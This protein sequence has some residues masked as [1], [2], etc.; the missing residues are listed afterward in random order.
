[1]TR[2]EARFLIR[3]ILFSIG[4]SRMNR[5]LIGEKVLEAFHEHQGLIKSVCVRPWKKKMGVHVVVHYEIWGPSGFGW[6][7]G[8]VA[9]PLRKLTPEIAVVQSV[10]LT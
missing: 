9:V 3:Q 5:D 1:M 2:E 7:K 10:L 8:F 4:L 6:L